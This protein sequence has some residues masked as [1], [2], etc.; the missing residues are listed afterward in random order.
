RSLDLY[1]LRYKGS[2]VSYEARL[3]GRGQ[4]AWSVLRN[5]HDRKSVDDRFDTIMKYMRE[6]FPSFDG[7]VL[8]QTGPTTVY[9]NLLRK[10][11]DKPLHASGASG[12]HLQML[13][14]LTT[15]FS[16]GPKPAAL[17]LDEPELSLH[18][19]PLTILARAVKDAAASWN[20]QVLIA[21]HSPVLLSQFETSECLA[22]GLQ[23]GRTRIQRLSE[24]EEIKDLLSEYSVGSLY[25]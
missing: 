21:T 20:K 4:N 25:M 18:P 12:G 2:D 3:E 8:E 13:L 1:G 24:N 15:L 10:G 5:L 19:W 9:A 14:L 22:T 7:L 23:D 17:L 16:E 11:S 6:S